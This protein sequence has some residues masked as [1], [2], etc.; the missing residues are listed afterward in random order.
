MRTKHC[1]FSGFIY[2]FCEWIGRQS[3]VRRLCLAESPIVRCIPAHL[4]GK[5]NRR[6][7]WK[8]RL[9]VRIN[10]Y[11]GKCPIRSFK[12]RKH[13]TIGDS[14]AFFRWAFVGWLLTSIQSISRC[15][16]AFKLLEINDKA[17]ILVP[18]KTV[19]DCGAAP[20]SW[21]QIAVEKTNANGKDKRHPAGFVI[22][23]DLL[24]IYPIEVSVAEIDSK[25]KRLTSFGIFRAPMCWAMQI[26]GCQKHRSWWKIYWMDVR[27]TAC[28]PTWR[29]TQLAS[30]H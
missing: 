15:R 27:S 29:R 16:S 28:C 14:L 12:W 21:T 30:V 4:C 2:I 11:H 22:G 19:V 6:K 10:G 8:E 3:V 20:G 13:V 1:G 26:F 25:W 24:N 7:L 5:M 18:G 17:N 9:T 23:L